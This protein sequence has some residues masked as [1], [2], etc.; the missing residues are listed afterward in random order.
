LSSYRDAIDRTTQTVD[1]RA[2]QFRNLIVAVT[3]VSVGAT[4]WAGLAWS[5]LPLTGILLLVPVCGLYLFLDGKLLN[6]WRKEL[7]V[8][9]ASGEIDFWAFHEAIKPISR[10]P[11]DTLKSMLETL[12]NAGDL[13]TEQSVSKNTRW[14]TAAVVNMV[15]SCRSDAIAFKTVRYTI[16]GSVVIALTAFWRWQP[17]LGMAAVG[18]LF[19]LQRGVKAK[20]LSGARK[21]IQAA[22]LE[23]DFSTETFLEIVSQINWS[24][25][26]PAEKETFLATL[27]EAS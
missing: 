24:P 20:R 21:K 3:L 16:I 25:I 1:N 7:F 13:V 12:P 18:L 6:Q 27:F 15:H 10:L 8:T 9:W 11:E 26:S 5:W 17:L 23:P 4:L 19:F 22:Q 2:K 14:T